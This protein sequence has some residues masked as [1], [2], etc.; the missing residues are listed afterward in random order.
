MVA[1]RWTRAVRSA[2]AP[3]L[4]ALVLALFGRTTAAVV[5]A[6]IAILLVVLAI[7][8]PR[9]I[10]AVDAALARAGRAV[11]GALGTI[12]GTLAWAF[13]VLPIWAASRL[14]GIDPLDRTRSSAPGW[15]AP[16]GTAPAPA[17]SATRLGAAPPVRRRPPLPRRLGRA[18]LLLALPVALLG[19]W[20]SWDRDSAPPAPPTNASA[21]SPIGHEKEPFAPALFAELG[22]ISG[23]WDSILGGTPADQEGRYVNVVD[24]HRVSYQPPD[25]TLTVWFF[26]GSTMYGIGQRDDHTIPSEIAR[27]A[28]ADGISIR[29]V[30]YGFPSYVNWLEVER[31]SQELALGKRPDLA[32]FY[33]GVN[34]L[35]LAAQRTQMGDTDPTVTSRQL[36][37]DYERRLWKKNRPEAKPQ[38]SDP[39]LTEQLAGQQ[40]GRGARLARILGSAYQV[41]V[42]LFWQP[43]LETKAHH[44]ADDELLDYLGIEAGA[45]PGFAE[46]VDQT[47][48]VSGADPIDLTDSLDQIQEPVFL[49]WGHTNELGAKTVAA[50]M[51]AELRPQLLALQAAS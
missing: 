45:L 33:D 19:A 9:T 27:L 32:V 42:T 8:T 26:G 36:I 25:P 28:Q 41:P 14:V 20:L 2:A 38:D 50:A 37:S 13:L 1:H 24:G 40:Y 48:T 5:V 16:D 23:R 10:A 46:T 31:F 39:A 49:D 47:I 34:E 4:A 30:N 3:A 12:I 11:G 7:T 51:Y 35:G 15:S 6:A 44:P 21:Y 17:I 43:S 29:A 18:A 22:K